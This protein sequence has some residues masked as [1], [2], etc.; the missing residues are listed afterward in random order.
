MGAVTRA[1][2]ALGRA[3]AM[4]IGSAVTLVWVVVVLVATAQPST[5]G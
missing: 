3:E 5:G 2:S 1:N 4:A